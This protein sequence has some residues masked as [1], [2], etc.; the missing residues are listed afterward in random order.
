MRY[1]IAVLLLTAA[2]GLAAQNITFLAPGTANPAPAS[3]AAGTTAHTCIQFQLTR[4]NASTTCSQ[5]V[6]GNSGTAG[7]ADFTQARLYHDVN[8]NG[9]FDGGDALLATAAS[10]AFPRT[11]AIGTPIDITTTPK[12]F[13]VVVDV[14]SGATTGNTFTL[15]VA[16][17]G[18]TVAAGTVQGGTVTGGTQTIGAAAAGP[19]ID[20]QRPAGTSIP[21]GLATTDSVGALAIGTGTGVTWTIANTGTSAL[22]LTGTPLVAI[23]NQFG[24]NSATVTT[25]PSASVA[26]GSS[27]AFTITINPSGATWGFQLS[28]AN[29]DSNENPY[30]FIVSGTG[31]STTVPEMDVQNASAAAIADGSTDSVGSHAAGTPFTLTY[32]IL[33]TGT[34]NLNLTGSP[35]VAIGSQ[36]NC[37]ATVT[38]NPGTPVAAAGQTTFDVEVTPTTAGMAFSFTISIDNNDANE[39]PYNWTVNGTAPAIVATQLV[40]T[41]Q[42]GNGTGGSALSTQPVVQARDAGGA[43]VSSYN[44][45]VTA[46]ITSG[47]G[48]AGATIVA[49]ASVNAVNGVATFTG[50]AIDLAGTGYTLTFTSGA[51][52]P[53]VS[54]TFNVAVGAATQLVITTQPGNGTG[55]S[56]LSPQPVVAIR[57]AG[58]NTVTSSAATVD[59]AITTGTGTTGAAIVAGG[60][61]NATG[62]VATF[63]AL[64]IDLAG[65]GYTLT[66]TS[67]SLTNAVSGTFNVTVG[68]AV[69]LRMVVQPAGAVAATAF[70]TQPQVEVIDAGGNR[71]TSSSASVAAGI[72]TGTGTSGATLGGT[73]PVSATAGLASFTNLSINLAGTG[74][75]LTFTSGSLTNVVSASFSVAGT[76]TQLGIATQPG[77]AVVNQPFVT[78]PVIEVRDAAG[79]LVAT[80]NTT[81]VVVTIASGTGAFTG[82]ST[83][84]LTAVNGVVTFTN[85]GI[86]TAGAGFSLDFDD[87]GAT[88]T[89]VTSATFS[90]AGAATQLVITTQPAGAVPG[91][92]FTTQPVIQIQD[93][94]GVLVATDNTTQVTVS[95][96]TGTGTTGA[97]L[98]GTTTLTAVN[99]VV[100]FTNLS[101]DLAGTGYTLDFSDAGALTD[102]TSAAF[103]VTAGGG[104]GSGG[105]D[106]KKKDSGCS[107]GT[108]DSAWLMLGALASLLALSAR[109]LRRRA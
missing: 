83:T 15:T 75:T 27:T 10:G 102:A 42:P 23:S 101:I 67:T 70:V 56:A 26:A 108:G 72:T 30:Q 44:G 52:T 106:G 47:T 39:N 11:F 6:V 9:S 94:A 58:G 41:T 78:Q 37:T 24:L 74:Y 91:T 84:T 59:A 48:A 17:A 65:T 93:A 46:A 76:P 88:L 36:N 3:V 85:L 90:V 66:F 4:S 20:V 82:T 18:V 73:T 53:A 87:V 79:T 43:L 45:L 92:A 22:S 97:V 51:L 80:D 21:S 1:A 100:S 50:L 103:D 99:G 69:A 77:G 38:A 49:G 61:V 7:A 33:N 12:S 60:S 96:T 68:A 98:G 107:T 13:I 104:G 62:G 95:I 8:A 32:T 5:V 29:D 40:I 34:A 25:Q 63:T 35:L 19:E 109:R 71:V 64:A 16:A 54:N 89:G 28:I 105:G 31:T 81:Q 2:G 14:A 55:G 57:D 86:N